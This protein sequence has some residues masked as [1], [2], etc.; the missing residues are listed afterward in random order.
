MRFARLTALA[1]LALGLSLA[2][3]RAEPTRWQPAR[4]WVFMVGVLEFQDSDAYPAFAPEGRLD[5]RLLEILK[6]RG[7]PED[8]VVYLQDGQ[9]TLSRI[10]RELSALL[11]RTKPG[12]TLL[13]DYFG[14]GARGEDGQGYFIASDTRGKDL[15]TTGWPMASVVET[16]RGEFQGDLVLMTADSCFSGSLARAVEALPPGG[17]PAIAALASSLSSEVSTVRWTFTESLLDAFAGR[18][19]ADLDGD[20]SIRL[21]ELATYTKRELAFTDH[22][23]SVFSH[24]GDLSPSLVLAPARRKKHPAIG[25]RLEAEEEGVWY[26]VKVVRVGPEGKWKVHYIGWDRRFDEWLSP[27][28]PRLREPAPVTFPVGATVEVKWK[29]EWFAAQVL[30][31][32][33][34][35]HYIH[36]LGDGDEWDE[37][38]APERIRAP[39]S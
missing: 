13:L 3:A 32:E 37:W 33:L 11:A 20:G 29:D 1:L 26:R 14:H 18:G 28:S 9:A 34:G 4:T 25:K 27:D 7:V 22:Q 30:R 35:L 8:R 36:Y 23:F 38:V 10:R 31:Q 17:G 19:Y 39:G 5:T 12:D 15:A 21:G 2:S 24:T 16:V 6:R